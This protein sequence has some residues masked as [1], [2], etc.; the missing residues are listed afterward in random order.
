MIK[1]HGKKS[2]D[3][4]DFHF[5]F[6]QELE[7]ERDDSGKVKEFRPQSNYKDK[8]T[9]KLHA[10]GKGS[11]CKF[12]ISA[13]W[14]GHS[15]VYA[16]FRDKELLYVG[17]CSDLHGRF[18]SRGY[19]SIQPKNCYEGGQPTNCKIN[20]MVLRES[21]AGAKVALYFHEADDYKRIEKMLIGTLKPPHNGRK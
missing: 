8:S 14:K 1:F 19:G 9:C 12:S 21:L 10:H 2:V 15:G 16:L 18:G 7:P 4:E 5:E 11:F 6:V 20:K 13:D 3:I 17:E